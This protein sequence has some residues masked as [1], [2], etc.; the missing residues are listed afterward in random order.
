MS[1]LGLR[2]NGFNEVKIVFNDIIWFDRDSVLTT[3][4]NTNYHILYIN[5]LSKI[6]FKY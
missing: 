2:N 1:V 3:L 6:T 4:K 5:N